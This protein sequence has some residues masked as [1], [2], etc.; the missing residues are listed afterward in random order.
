MTPPGA[1]PS[2]AADRVNPPPSSRLAAADRDVPCHRRHESCRRRPRSA[3]PWWQP[4]SPLA[5]VPYPV[6]PWWQQGPRHSA[7][8]SS[9]AACMTAP[10][11]HRVGSSRLSPRGLQPP[12][13]REP[14]GFNRP[15]AAPPGG[16][17][18]GAGPPAPPQGAAAPPGGEPPAQDLC[19]RCM[20]L[21]PLPTGSCP[22]QEPPAPPQGAGRPPPSSP[23]AVPLSHSV[24]SA[25]DAVIDRDGRERKRGD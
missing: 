18:P 13:G 4:Q 15:S 1:A 12:Q 20:E 23:S 6:L 5:S 11:L 21:R 22:A 25:S 17:P 19:R 8:T 9:P 24:S 2:I 14:P 7:S 3:L 16:E 10:P